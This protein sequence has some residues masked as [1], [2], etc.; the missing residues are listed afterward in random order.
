MSEFSACCEK[1]SEKS[2]AGGH[3][4]DEDV[5]V[6]RMSPVANGT[7]AVERGDT[8]G[9]GEVSIGAASDRTFTEGEIH[10]LCCG[11]GA[12]EESRTH[13]AFKRRAVEATADF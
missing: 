1:S 2:G 4:F 10:L 9:C 5:L 6:R 11:F 7:E 8:Q 12:R 13:F 3:G